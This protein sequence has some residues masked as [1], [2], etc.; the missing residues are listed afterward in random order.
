MGVQG[1]PEFA[2]KMTGRGV[3]RQTVH[4]VSAHRLDMMAIALAREDGGGGRGTMHGTRVVTLSDKH[5]F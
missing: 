4:A 3:Q 1:E 2:L 5:L